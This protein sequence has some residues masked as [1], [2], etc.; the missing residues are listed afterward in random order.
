M[1]K[2]LTLTIGGAATGTIF[3]LI[4]VGI[5]LS[6][7]ATGI[8][9]FAYGAIAFSAAFVYYELRSALHWP[10]AAAVLVSVFVAGPIVGV[11]LDRVIFRPLA[12]AT[13]SAKIMATVGL[14]IALPAIVRFVDKIIIDD[15]HRKLLPSDNLSTVVGSSIGPVPPHS[16]HVVSGVRMNSDQLIVLI[17]AVLVAVVL[18]FV[19][20]RTPLG[21]QMR[22][23]VDRHEL[24]QLRGVNP[25]KTSTLAWI[26]GTTVCGLAGVAGAPLLGSLIPE[27]FTL[28]VFIASAAAVFGGLRSIPLAFAGGMIIG[29]LRN[30]VPGYLESIAQKIDGLGD[31]IP[32]IILFAALI[33]LS[34]D[35]R[36]TAGSAADAVPPP[37]HTADLTWFRRG[38][39]WAVAGCLLLLF[40]VW[41]H[42]NQ[43]WL[44]LLTKSLIF[45]LIFLSFVVVTGIGGMV[46][47]AQ[48]AFV[49]A[50]GLTA[51]LLIDRYHFNF[52]AALVVAVIVSV[53]IGILVALPALRLGGLSLALATLALAFLGDDVLFKWTYLRHSGSGWKI[54]PPVVGPFH[55]TD[56]RT[57]AFLVLVL[58]AI[59]IVMIRN[60]QRS[61]TGRAM[62]AARTSEPAA[63][64]SGVSPLRT[65]LLLFAMSAAIA[66]LGGVLLATYNQSVTNLSTPA[67]LGLLWLS[68]VVLFG[69]RRPVGAFIAG[70]SSTVFPQILS[71]GFRWPWILPSFIG[72]HGTRNPFIPQILF[73][74]GAIQLARQPDGIIS[75]T[76]G[77]NRARRLRRQ[78]K[79]AAAAAGSAP[80]DE[81]VVELESAL[82]AEDAAIAAQVARHSEQFATVTHHEAAGP[83]TVDG[84]APRLVLTDVH[85]GYGEVEVLHGISLELKPGRVLALLGANGAGKSTLCLTIAGLV[86]VTS[87]EITLAGASV[88]RL[89]AYSRAGIG[90]VLAPE[91]RGIFPGLSVQENL[92]LWLPSASDRDKAYEQ[93]PVLGERRR[94]QAGSLSGGEQQMLTLAPLLV[95]PPEVLVADEP[96]LGLA[97]RIT[98]E[99]MA[100]FARLREQGVALLLVEEKARDVLNVADE[101]AFLEL[102]HIGWTG[103][104]ADVDDERLAA[105]Y[106]GRRA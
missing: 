100:L 23:V 61:A 32:F 49:S 73:G 42:H 38:L 3:S 12:R 84:I 78:A 7:T 4:A 104:R 2:F 8:Y 50:S 91:S 98:A 83:A 88:T 105:A 58:I 5:V 34:R 69:I 106:L 13:D 19:M 33:I 26:M 51:G 22:A 17:V 55:L 94:L 67:T 27:T 64:T 46:S 47:L 59:T 92:T 6:Y 93:F 21:L 63:A 30:L 82:Q 99:I 74:A 1:D 77:Q 39:P 41:P 36:R 48:A 95:R 44:G 20:R 31:A 60:L 15:F 103:P 16:W 96:S 14:L 56:N 68:S 65:K 70:I 75:L 102:G 90:L 45:S 87:G 37:D 10:V 57:M 53:V 79:K 80:L 35:R 29:V 72:W 62:I 66:G 25:R 40:I 43:F 24:A 86:P 76:A 9:N 11:L 18:W 89:S 52:I 101:V 81:S 97:P 71:G 85:A 28:F 54:K